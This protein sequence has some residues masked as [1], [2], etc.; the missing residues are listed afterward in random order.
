[1][2]RLAITDF[3]SKEESEYFYINEEYQS[4]QNMFTY[5]SFKKYITPPNKYINILSL[6]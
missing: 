2:V 3:T 6:F 4:S 5:S 1:M